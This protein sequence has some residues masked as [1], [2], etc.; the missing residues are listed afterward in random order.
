[1]P[2]TT[3]AFEDIEEDTGERVFMGRAQ[4]NFAKE[5]GWPTYKETRD[6]AET[7]QMIP[8]SGDQTDAVVRH[9]CPYVKGAS[10][11]LTSRVG[12]MSLC[13]KG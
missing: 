9:A 12:G 8:F 2:S 3:T 6:A 5:L 1:L 7:I 13:I 10:E 11:T 4:L